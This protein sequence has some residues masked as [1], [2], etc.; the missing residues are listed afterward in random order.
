M[1]GETAPSSLLLPGV[2]GS[3]MGKWP[4]VRAFRRPII[5]TA[6]S[7]GVLS[8]YKGKKKRLPGPGG[9]A[10]DRRSSSI[11]RWLHLA[12]IWENT[13]P[14]MG[15]IYG[16][17]V[18]MS[19]LLLGRPSHRIHF[20]PSSGSGLSCASVGS[21]GVPVGVCPQ[22]RVSIFFAPAT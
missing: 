4:D 20:A 16:K 3:E 19:N 8:Y 11:S 7:R 12:P 2:Q 14:Q 9:G 13:M 18:E 21:A 6:A 15:S 17:V 5:G 10:G 1:V 22:R